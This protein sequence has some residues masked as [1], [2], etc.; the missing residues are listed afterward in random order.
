MKR[1]WKIVGI[2]TLVAVLGVAAVGAVA[3][4]QDDEAGWPF[5]FGQ[6][7]RE[8]IAGI[9]GISVEEY[10]AAVEQ[11]REQV[12]DEAQAEGWLTEE[13]AEQMRE[14]MAEGFGPRGMDRGF[15]RPGP[16]N[17]GKAMRDHAGGLV[18]VAAGALDMPVKDLFTELKDGKSIAAVAAEQG[19]DTQVVV[20]AYLDA[21]EA[22]LDEA[23]ANGKLTQERADWMLEQAAERLPDQ[24]DKAFEGCAPGGFPHRGRPGGGM[25]GVPGIPGESDA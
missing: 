19:V 25:R 8:A 5:N 17:M 13:Q 11:A 24:L 21:I 4:A 10:A 23:V 6:N 1:F 22:R 16:G 14:K 12:V 15:M 20:N 3:Y 9:L 2:A 18:E 7:F